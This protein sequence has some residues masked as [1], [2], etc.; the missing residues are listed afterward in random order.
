MYSVFLESAPADKDLLSAELWDLGAV[1]IVERDLPG[2]NVELQAFFPEPVVLPAPLAG[3][4]WQKEAEVDWVRVYQDAW[5]PFTVGERWFLTPEWRTDPPPE[6]RLRLI[7]HPGRACGT[8]W[9][10]ATQL[11]LM[12]LEK[13]LKPGET[14]LDLGAGSG[15]LSQAAALLGARRIAACDIDF[16]AAAIAA[17][18]LAGLPVSVFAGST[19]ALRDGAADFT[20][21]NI[22]AET[23]VSLASEIARLTRR[24]AA[25]AGF[26]ERDAP[27]VRAA[28]SRHFNIA[29]ADE[30]DG[31][32]SLVG[33]RAMEC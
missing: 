25:V 33:F 6:G 12:A 13:H 3:A 29:A 28:L 30:L 24:C 19:R 17:R 15:I 7:I 27:R 26:P 21:A 5:Q 8:G 20:V 16:E 14:V 4:R 32:A 31:W 9:H 10:P 23:I 11:S 1:G 22:N 18:N 2:G